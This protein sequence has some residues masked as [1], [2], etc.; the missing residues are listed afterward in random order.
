[1]VEG[2]PVTN[3]RKQVRK[4]A[5]LATLFYPT[6]SGSQRGIVC[7]LSA[8]GVFVRPIGTL[9][10][11]FGIGSRVRVVFVAQVGKAQRTVDAHGVVRWVG[12]SQ[13]HGTSGVG[14]E[15]EKTNTSLLALAGAPAELLSE[16]T[17]TRPMES[18]LAA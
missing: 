14:I 11:Q 6:G 5:A 15:L 18:P 1:M 2:M 17:P 13:E 7:D 4:K 12:H 16:F 3:D 10:A 8:R 9:P